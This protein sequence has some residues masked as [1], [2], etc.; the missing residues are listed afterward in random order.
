VLKLLKKTKKQGGNAITNPQ[1]HSLQ[2]RKLGVSEMYNFSY[3]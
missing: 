2:G 1:S 3:E